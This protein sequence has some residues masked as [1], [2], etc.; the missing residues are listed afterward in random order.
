MED[1]EPFYPD[2]MAGRILG[3]GDVLSFV[4]KAQEVVSIK[5]PIFWICS[6][7]SIN[8]LHI[9]L[10]H[11][12]WLSIN[13]V[14]ATRRCWRFA[15]EDNECKIWFQWLLEANSCGCT[16]GLNV[17]CSWNDSRHGKG[18]KPGLFKVMCMSFVGPYNLLK[19]QHY[20][21]KK[22]KKVIPSTN[23]PILIAVL[24]MSFISSHL[25]PGFGLF[26]EWNLMK[27]I[28]WGYLQQVRQSSIWKTCIHVHQ[29]PRAVER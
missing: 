18:I 13:W 14:D 8:N 15:E 10:N 7:M 26:C 20:V 11:V 23:I 21:P 24:E 12:I 29:M 4:E 16:D 3:M 9:V 1:L 17:S 22:D 2:R 5:F 27:V 6:F 25:Y 28:L 19:D